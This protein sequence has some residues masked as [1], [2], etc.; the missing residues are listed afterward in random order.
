MR[1][2]PL[3]TLTALT[4]LCASTALAEGGFALD[5]YEPSE[6][7]SDWFANE[8]LDLRGNGRLALGAVGDY[9]YKPLVFYDAN[10]DEQALSLIHI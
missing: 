6:R 9:A 7:G 2:S 8:S 1:R 4:L 10:G 3:F 5:R